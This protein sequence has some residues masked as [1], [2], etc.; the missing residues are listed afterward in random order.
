MKNF[1]IYNFLI[2]NFLNFLQVVLVFLLSI[3]SLIIY[4]VDTRSVIL[5]YHFEN[6]ILKVMK[7]LY[8]N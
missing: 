3:A 7:I 1:N 6:S 8:N 4:F 5:I 2:F